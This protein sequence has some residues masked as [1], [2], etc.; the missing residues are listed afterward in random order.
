MSRHWSERLSC[1]AC[2]ATF[3][4]AVAEARHRHNF[5]TMCKRSKQFARFQEE[6]ARE[7]AAGS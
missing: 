2:G 5:P 3:R 6:V 4:S 7:R 1:H